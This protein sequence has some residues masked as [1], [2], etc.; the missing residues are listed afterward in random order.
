MGQNHLLRSTISRVYWV[1]SQ[2]K[3][4]NHTSRFTTKID[5]ITDGQTRR[6]AIGGPMLPM[7]MTPSAV[8]R[9]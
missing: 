4:E 6:P 8:F 5:P 3:R 2:I 7:P 1:D 9:R